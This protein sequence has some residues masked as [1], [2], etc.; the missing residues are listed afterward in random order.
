MTY[1]ELKAEYI[2]FAIDVVEQFGY[3][4]EAREHRKGYY[5]HGGLSTLENAFGILRRA[6]VARKN[7]WWKVYDYEIQ[8]YWKEKKEPKTE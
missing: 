4:S 7:K 3:R 6:G 8:R 5:S 2:E 1:E